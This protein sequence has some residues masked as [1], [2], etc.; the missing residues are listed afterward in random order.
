M[1]GIFSRVK[2]ELYTHNKF[3]FSFPVHNSIFGLFQLYD[4]SWIMKLVLL[5]EEKKIIYNKE[6][7]ALFVAVKEDDHIVKWFINIG[8]GPSLGCIHH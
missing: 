3:F 8:N 2:V 5:P 4:I 1:V 6:P 7:D